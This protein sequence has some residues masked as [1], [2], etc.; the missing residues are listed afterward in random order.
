VAGK[1]HQAWSHRAGE[2]M[3]VI[4]AG[5]V[6]ILEAEPELGSALDPVAFRAASQRCAAQAVR[7]RRGALW[8]VLDP[9]E[10]AELLGFLILGGVLLCRIR[11]AGRET[12]DILGPGDVVRPCLSTD[13]YAELLTSTSWHAVQTLELATLDSDLLRRAA[14]W[15]ELVVA[16]GDRIA[17]HSRSLAM[18]LAIA[19]I[20]NLDCRL[21]V[22]FWHLA[23]RFGRVDRDGLLVPLLLTQETLAEMVGAQRPSVNRSLRRLAARGLLAADPRGWRLRGAPPEEIRPPDADGTDIPMH[24]R[25]AQHV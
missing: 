2:A 16:L 1:R 24:H 12:V 17:Q 18:R 5:R 21:Q 3:P 8:G 9:I 4:A 20:P 14:P 23:D 22:M 7:I 15:P 11:I 6:R 10:D 19:Q 13:E 25:I